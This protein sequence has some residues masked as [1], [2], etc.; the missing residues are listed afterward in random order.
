MP[1]LPAWVLRAARDRV[2]SLCVTEAKA[3]CTTY[4]QRMPASCTAR[5]SVREP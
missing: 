4:V 2:F 1:H 5:H 3:Y